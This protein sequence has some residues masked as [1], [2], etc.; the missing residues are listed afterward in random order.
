M[1]LDSVDAAI[2]DLVTLELVAGAI[3]FGALALVAF[4]VIRLGVNPIRRMTD[5][6]KRNRG[7]GP[8]LTRESAS[9]TEAG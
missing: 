7:G 6:R 4:W 3:I 8:D 5:T 2:D 1:P 9:G